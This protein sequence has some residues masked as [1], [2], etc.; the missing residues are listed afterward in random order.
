[1]RSSS[2]PDPQHTQAGE[3]RD[4]SPQSESRLGGNRLV[5]AEGDSGYRQCAATVH[6]EQSHRAV[7]S[8]AHGS[9]DRAGSGVQCQPCGQGAEGDLEHG[10]D[11]GAGDAGADSDWRARGQR[12]GRVS[13][14]DRC[15]HTGHIT[16]G[17]LGDTRVGANQKPVGA[18][19]G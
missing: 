10:V 9:G 2:N 16:P 3:K 18:G 17:L 12:G 6:S 19:S 1:M 13:D 11:R 14:S 4:H 7:A 8:A 15:L 5:A